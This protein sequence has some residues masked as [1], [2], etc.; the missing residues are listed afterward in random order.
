LVVFFLKAIV[1]KPTISDGLKVLKVNN[2]DRINVN[3]IL[4]ALRNNGIDPEPI[5]IART[6]ITMAIRIIKM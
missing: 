3:I 6:N 1:K 5:Y 2:N 4:G